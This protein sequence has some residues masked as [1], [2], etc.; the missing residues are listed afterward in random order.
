MLKVT[1]DD[2][3]GNDGP[4]CRHGQ[5]LTL[6]KAAVTQKGPERRTGIPGNRH[7]AH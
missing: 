4:W 2:L 7:L 5:A 3:L 6:V 1:R